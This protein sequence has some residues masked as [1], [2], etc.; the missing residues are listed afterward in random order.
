VSIFI[1]SELQD[2]SVS[3]DFQFPLSCL[4]GL[5]RQFTCEAFLSEKICS[6]SMEQERIQFPKGKQKEFIAK[7]KSLARASWAKTG[8][9]FD[10]NN[11]TFQGYWKER[12]RL[13]KKD[14]EKICSVLKLD[15]SELLEEYQGEKYFWDYKKQIV[16]IGFA[17]FGRIKRLTKPIE[18]TF[19]D[20]SL[21]LDCSMVNFSRTDFE[22]KIILPK[23]ITPLL[24][25]EV[26]MSIGDGY[27]SNNKYEYR[28]KG[29]KEN[30]KEYYQTY[31][32]QMFRRL[33]NIELNIK[34]YNSTIGFENYSKA[35]WEFK[36]KVLNLSIAPKN[37]IRIP[38]KLKINNKEILCA[39]IRGLFDTDGSIYFRSQGKNKYY[40]PVISYASISKDLINDI[41][42]ILQMLGFNSKLYS[43]FKITKSCPNPRYT[44]VL[45]GYSNFN[46][47]KK[48]INTKQPKNIYK[49]KTWEE[50][51]GK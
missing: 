22:K 47:Y 26:G 48:L 10:I 27:I 8:Q 31:V 19:C 18:L 15:Q 28:L 39:L 6:F 33:Y 38:E 2:Y 25:E 16:D 49:L 32:K 34:E 1:Y 51:F 29:N 20:D 17:N 30:E 37:T 46:L 21:L 41:F 43:S 14:F 11:N 50:R 5:L 9:V 40:Y 44:I 3:T 13:S 23:E 36:T 12:T 24:A 45:C 42:E 7:V 35:L 4:F